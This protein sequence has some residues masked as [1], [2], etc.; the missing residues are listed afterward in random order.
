MTTRLLLVLALAGCDGDLRFEGPRDRAPPDDSA[1]F[2][3]STD[4]ECTRENARRCDVASHRCVECGVAADCEDNETCEPATKRCLRTCGETAS[5]PSEQPFCDPRGLC[6]CTAASCTSS[7]RRICDPTGRC[8]ECVN[9][10][11]C[12]GDEPRCDLARGE[13]VSAL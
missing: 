9:D 11:S 13:C 10:S 12:P 3:C 5:C 8:V 6:V 4:A 7:D 2:E 1:T